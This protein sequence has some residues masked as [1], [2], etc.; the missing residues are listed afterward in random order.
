MIDAERKSRIQQALRD[1]NL[2][3]VICALPSNVLLLTGYWP[4]V[5]NS[6]AL[7][8]RD[9]PTLLLAPEDESELA[10][11]GFADSVDTFVPETLQDTRTVCQAVKPHLANAFAQLK[12]REA[13]IG[14][15][16]ADT[17]QAASYLAM[18]LYG[19]SL[20]QLILELVP[21]S[22]CLAADVLF[23]KLKSIKTPS[24]LDRIRQ[25]CAIAQFAFETAAPLLSPE[26]TENQAAPLFRAPLSDRNEPENSVRRCDGFAFCMSGP[27]SAKAYAAYARTR[28]RKLQP[29]DLVMIH[30]N[31]YVDGL[32]TDITRTYTL[33]PPDRTQQRIFEAVFAAREAALASIRPG[34]R[35]ADVDVA[36]ARV[37]RD[38][39]FANYVK[40]GTGHGVGFSSM[41]ACSIPRLHQ[42]STDVL[43]PGMV[44]NVEPALYL[45][46]YG[47]V[48]HCDMVHV[49]ATG[50]EL[51]TN[52]HCSPHSLALEP[53]PAD[54]P[55]R[56][57]RAIHSSQLSRRISFASLR[58]RLASL[59]VTALVSA[60]R[61]AL[62][63]LH[64]RNWRFYF[65]RN[66]F[67]PRSGPAKHIRFSDS[68]ESEQQ[69][70]KL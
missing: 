36:T 1:A 58:Y 21:D 44:F 22:T 48:R 53:A 66:L 35:A 16:A 6:V 29:A 11:A 26:L 17:S 42:G 69:W 12:L 56:A 46:G 32:W 62:R 10:S 2:D 41:S 31:S 24:E 23:H 64:P 7:C 25:A 15:E 14:I 19:H 20:R 50:H 37:M 49:T 33:R 34:A 65:L 51:L 54:S 3:A 43:A 63:R 60:Y 57:N 38:R 28:H 70:P 47:G 59:Q 27:N 18:F 5:G 61:R 4:I 39:G 40:H 8:L 45:D 13:R 30:C 52:F 55:L 67:G 68:L 9:G